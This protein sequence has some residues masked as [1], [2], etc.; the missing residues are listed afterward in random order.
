M[1]ITLVKQNN[2]FLRGLKTA[3]SGD[4][5][6]HLLKHALENDHEHVSEKRFQDNW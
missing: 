3:T 6:S 2:E 5:K 4:I 1:I